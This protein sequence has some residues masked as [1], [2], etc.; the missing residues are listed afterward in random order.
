[1]AFRAAVWPAMVIALTSALR[2]WRGF[3]MAPSCRYAATLPGTGGNRTSSLEALQAPVVRSAAGELTAV[4]NVDARGAPTQLITLAFPL[5]GHRRATSDRAGEHTVEGQIA[6]NEQARG[7]SPRPGSNILTS[8]D[9]TNCGALVPRVV[10][11]AVVEQI[12]RS[13]RCPA[14]RLSADIS[15][16]S[17]ATLALDPRSTPLRSSRPCKSGKR[18]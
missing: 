11:T 1:V 15:H 9:A 12:T 6:R 17:G 3:A 10:S 14:A 8:A 7:S 2:V 4:D 18:D 16:P 13:C 5:P